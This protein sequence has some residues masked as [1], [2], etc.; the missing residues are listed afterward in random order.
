MKYCTTYKGVP[1]G[2]AKITFTDDNADKGLSFKALGVFSNGV[3]SNGPC[4]VRKQTD[5]I[6]LFTQMI[7][8]RPADN[9]YSTYIFGKGK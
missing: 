6:K 4:L 8:G 1:F 3:L 5:E 7:E 2:L 9:Y